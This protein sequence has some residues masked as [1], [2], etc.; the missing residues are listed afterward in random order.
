MRKVILALF[1]ALVAAAPASA[2]PNWLGMTGLIL[3]PS[4]DALDA[5]EWNVTF[6]HITDTANIAAGNLGLARG[7]EAGLVF[8]DPEARGAD[9]E[10]TG[11]AKYMVIPETATG[12]GFAVGWWDFAD[13]VDSSP[14]AV[15]S[16]RLRGDN[17]GPAFRVHVGGGGGIY[18]GIFAGA[19][20]NLTSNILAM[21]DYDGEDV[22]AG[23]RIGLPSGFRLDA[24]F[25]SEEFGIGASYN[26]RF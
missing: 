11:H 8:F 6:H 15:V 23:V 19:E 22:N 10:L 16:K 18:D 2:A 1:A 14:Y 26:A 4:A 5:R 21:V 17:E 24:A 9:A 7:L 3:T 13:Q 25:V 12:V 20:A